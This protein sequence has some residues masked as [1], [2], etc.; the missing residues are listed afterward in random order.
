MKV[1]IMVSTMTDKWEEKKRNITNK[2][3]KEKK[4]FI[5]YWIRKSK[6]WNA[7]IILDE[8]CNIIPK[9][10]GKQ[11]EMERRWNKWWKWEILAYTCQLNK[12]KCVC[13]KKKKSILN[14]KWNRKPK[15]EKKNKK[16]TNICGILLLWRFVDFLSLWFR[17]INLFHCFLIVFR[18]FIDLLS[19]S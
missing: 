6:S 16:I 17:S 4:L 19:A 5:L 15:S 3:K 12:W 10:R 14:L 7:L 11:S 1:S 8:L 2:D 13:D 18:Y 9:R